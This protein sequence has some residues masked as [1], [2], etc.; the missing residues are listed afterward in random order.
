MSHCVHFYCKLTSLQHRNESISVSC[1]STCTLPMQRTP[2]ALRRRGLSPLDVPSS[3]LRCMPN[4]AFKVIAIYLLPMFLFLTSELT[5]SVKTIV[6]STPT[7]TKRSRKGKKKERRK[8]EV[9]DEEKEQAV[10]R[11]EE[12]A[13]NL[14]TQ[15]FHGN[16]CL[17]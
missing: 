8:E 4:F 11:S 15:L 2:Y 17:V 13:L 9:A 3:C 7:K 6:T 10:K 16:L 14:E 5:S 12:G 1:A